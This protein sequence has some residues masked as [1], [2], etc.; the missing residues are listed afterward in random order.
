MDITGYRIVRTLGRGGMATVYLAEQQSVQREV[1]LKVMA[2]VLQGDEQFGE[3]FLREARIAAKLRHPGVVQVHDVGICGEHHYIAMEYL[4]GGPVM[5]RNGAARPVDFA[6]R[7]ASQ[8]ASA[9]DYAGERGIV[10]RDIKPDNILL[11]EDGAAVL[12]DF[13]I[14]RASDASRMTRTGAIVGTPHY[15]S[16]EQARGQ[17]LDGRADLYSLGIVLHELLLGRVPY[18]ASDSLAI[19]IMHITAPLPKLPGEFAALQPILDRMLAKDPAQRYQRG[20][21]VAAALDAVRRTSGLSGETRVMPATP[22]PAPTP[23]W[24]EPDEPRLG[25]IEEVLHTP[26]R[27]RASGTGARRG[28]R[29]GWL[30]AAVVVL[31]ALGGGLYLFQD[32]LREQL[33]HTRMNTLLLE[34]DEALRQGRLSG[35]EGSA[36]ER[37]L[38][39]LAHDPDSLPAQRGLQE[40]GRQL[41]VQARAALAQGDVAPATELLAHAQSL[42]LPAADVADLARALQVRESRDMELGSLL[43]AAR[44]AADGGTLDG[45]QDSAVALYR[46]ALTLD[47]GNAVAAAGLRGVLAS[48]LE[49]ARQAIAAGQF[50]AASHTI[51]R[52]AA[53]DSTH[54][55]LP[56]ARA[57]LAQARQARSDDMEGQLAAADALLAR[58][59]LVPPRQPNALQGY[60]AVLVLDPAQPRALEGVRKVAAALLVQADRRIEDYQFDAARDLIDQAR[61]LAPNLPALAATQRRYDSVR[62]RRG[63]VEAQ[64]A[65]TAIDIPATL[66][67]ARDAAQAG[68]FLMPPGESAYDLYRAVLAQASGHAQARA[69]LA[70]LPDRAM[71]RFE[72][73]MTGNR[74]GTARDALEAMSVIAP[75]DGRL[76]PARQRLARSYLA[77]A[78]E[79]IGAGEIDL[80]A[81]A[82]DQAREL[83]PANTELPAIQARLEQARGG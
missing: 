63:Q 44:A 53:L 38:A 74:L 78:S 10:H 58:G 42:S 16:P 6:L 43:D 65:I 31:A 36:R 34:A 47:P 56:E 35:G 17:P 75:S 73:A 60:Q 82:F 14:A 33:P 25:R 72:D 79:R 83:D 80:A 28:R 67:R 20:R 41:L 68:K 45:D 21:D 18:Q 51:E 62:E 3:R 26:T 52:V 55:G 59:Q 15:M 9:L 4:P 61:Q 5:G 69:G 48:L 32:R 27:I 39:A 40:V 64:Q 77:Y 29:W 70:A 76:V 23:D 37:Y 22:A 49:Q 81:R 30:A 12:T 66:Q 7:V 54:L 13:G 2:A 71:Q 11:R 19:G 8:I 1:A 57:L 50:D 24:S 46:R